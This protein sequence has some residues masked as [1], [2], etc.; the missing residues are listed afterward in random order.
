[1]AGQSDDRPGRRSL[2]PSDSVRGPLTPA[3]GIPAPARPSVFGH[4]AFW[5]SGEDWASP[6]DSSR[7]PAGVF[8][9]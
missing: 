8:D 1:M 9:P 2:L 3:V 7:I 4:S 6:A 5:D